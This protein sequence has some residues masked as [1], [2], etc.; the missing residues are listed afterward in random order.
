MARL[1]IIDPEAGDAPHDLFSYAALSREDEASARED[2]AIIRSNIEYIARKGA[3]A[4]FALLR[5]KERMPHG[6][7]L[8]WVR[9]ECHLSE[10]TAQAFMRGANNVRDNPRLNEGF[11]AGKISLTAIDLMFAS[12]TPQPVRDQVEALL[13]DGQKVTVADIRRA[14]GLRWRPGAS[15]RIH[16]PRKSASQRALSG[17][18]R[19]DRRA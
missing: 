15:R 18:R 3:E 14:A 6:T 9:D 11:N 4:G 16:W 10:G 7:F 17:D 13:V 1:K 2:A 5:Q 19:D 12:G 8:A